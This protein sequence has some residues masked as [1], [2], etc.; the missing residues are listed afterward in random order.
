MAET[1]VVVEP[2]SN[3]GLYARL[4]G[5]LGFLR[6]RCDRDLAALVE[7][8]LPATAVKALVRGGLSDAEVHQLIIPR[9]TLAH[10][11]AKHQP[12]SKEESDKAVRV[13]RIMAMAEEVFGEPARAWRWMRKP[14]RRFDGK[15]PL[16]MLASEAGARLVEE[17][18]AQIDDG[19][20][21]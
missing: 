8:R 11:T 21:A 4:G 2:A 10:R 13:A 6:I 15:T 17:T 9:R 18:I 16:E 20:A 12:L 3:A 5:K 14:K 19:L 1:H 7:R